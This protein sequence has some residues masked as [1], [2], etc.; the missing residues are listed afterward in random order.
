M[1]PIYKSEIVD[2]FYDIERGLLVQQ[3][4]DKPVDMASDTE[5]KR[6]SFLFY[7]A[8]EIE[9]LFNKKACQ[10]IES[11]LQTLLLNWEPSYFPQA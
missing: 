10:I 11:N 5:T 1:Y 8:S 4:K 9:N 7:N 2:I 6:R 3:W